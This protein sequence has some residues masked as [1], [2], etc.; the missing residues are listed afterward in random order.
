M[1]GKVGP[2]C[3]WY[4]GGPPV[5]FLP[6]PV[7]DKDRQWGSQDCQYCTECGKDS[8]NGHYLSIDEIVKLAEE[9]QTLE[10][11]PPPKDTIKAFVDSHGA[12]SEEELA[13]LAKKCLLPV[14]D[15]AKFADHLYQIAKRR[16]K[17]VKRRQQ[18]VAEEATDEGLVQLKL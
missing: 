2:E 12:P 17:S 10:F 14:K 18:K 6:L 11:C 7:A 13:E 4:Q 9:G 15:V 1:N 3:L 16:K 5:T 8:C